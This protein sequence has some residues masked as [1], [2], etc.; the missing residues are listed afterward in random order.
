MK[1]TVMK[2]PV[3]DIEDDIFS[4]LNLSSFYKEAPFRKEMVR[5]ILKKAEI[6]PY[7]P[8][9][10]VLSAKEID[11]ISERFKYRRYK[12]SDILFNYGD[13][14]DVVFIVKTGEVL[15]YRELDSEN[16][17]EY[18]IL[19]KADIFGEMGVISGS[20]RSLSASIY[21]DMAELYVISRE[22][23]LYMLKKYPE[24]AVNLCRILC[25]RV[26]EANKRL[27]DDK[28]DTHRKQV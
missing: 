28:K 27:L 7:I 22:D 1:K 11:R 14:A 12:K 6:I 16:R 13:E 17:I 25:F 2:S 23:F 20:P 21:S 4:T 10:S 24:L 8:L 18:A 9:F 19:F 3:K 5:K 26:E 15:L